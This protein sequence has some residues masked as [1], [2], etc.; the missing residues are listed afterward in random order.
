[1]RYIIVKNNGR[2]LSTFL[3]Y[4]TLEER[5]CFMNKQEFDNVNTYIKK[6]ARF[7]FFHSLKEAEKHIKE[8][9][10]ENVEIFRKVGSRYVKTTS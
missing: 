2:I 1:M 3:N 6:E 5:D 10:Y 7:H 4:L 8:K 9:H